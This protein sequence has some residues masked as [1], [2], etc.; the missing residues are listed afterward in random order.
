MASTEP[1]RKNLTRQSASIPRKL[2][3]QGALHLIVLYYMVRLSDL[4]REGIEH[5]GSFRF[6]DHIYR[7]TPSGRTRL[8]RWIDA[9]LLAT[10]AAQAFRRRYERAQAIARLA[11]ESFPVAMRPLRILAVPCGI[12]RDMIDLSRT[13]RSENPALLSRIEY[14]GL[15]IDPRALAAASRLTAQCG[16]SSAQYHCGDALNGDDYPKLTFD[17][18][19]ST[20]LGEFLSDDELTTF[21][22]RVFNVMESGAT[23]YTSATAKDRRSDVLLRMAELVTIYRGP[24]ELEQILRRWPWRRLVLRRD[25]TGLQTFV[26]AVK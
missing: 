1:H 11:L 15:D 3:R 7:G 4:G 18:V 8:G 25:A 23:F 12:P 20:G 16:L 2:L 26:A 6:A 14:H 22:G 21:Y 17:V 5:S 24:E 19:I 9:R 13:L 10:P